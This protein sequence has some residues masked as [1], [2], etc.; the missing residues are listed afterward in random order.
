[1][2]WF[3]QLCGIARKNTAGAMNASTFNRKAMVIDGHHCRIMQRMRIV[4]D[5][6]DTANTYDAPRPL[7]P[8]EWSPKNMDGHHLLLKKLGQT[9]C[10]PR[11]PDCA[12]CFAQ[13]DCETGKRPS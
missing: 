12:N 1:M 2:A 11:A 9:H 7:L 10:R 4:P 8:Q 6:A 3:E 5:K 13:D